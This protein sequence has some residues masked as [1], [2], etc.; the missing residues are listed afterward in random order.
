[1]TAQCCTLLP[2]HV[3]GVASSGHVISYAF[4]VVYSKPKQSCMNCFAALQVVRQPSVLCL[5][6]DA[7]PNKCIQLAQALDTT[8]AEAAALARANPALLTLAAGTIH[9]KLACLHEA[10]RDAERLAI[11]GQACI[12]G[13]GAH[14]VLISGGECMKVQAALAT[15]LQGPG[16]QVGSA[17]AMRLVRGWR[18]Q[19]DAASPSIKAAYGCFSNQRYARLC[20]LCG[21]ALEAGGLT[22]SA[23]CIAGGVVDEAPSMVN[24]TTRTSKVDA[25][26]LK[27]PKVA[28]NTAHG[29][30]WSLSQILRADDIKFGK[31]LAE[32]ADV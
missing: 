24:G 20:M 25:G 1:M 13:A 15:G 32:M 6:S 5:S 2:Y 26:R 30:K 12:Q 9:R 18:E 8:P 4:M 10:L 17:L 22:R 3:T 19:L 21:A 14:E 23:V 11:E 16:V 27:L 29:K 7:V 31:M 28:S